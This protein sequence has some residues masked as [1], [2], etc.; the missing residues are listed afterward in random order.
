MAKYK[1]FEEVPVWQQA[2]AL[3]NA[4]LDLL[5]AHHTLLT[6]GYRNQL[7]RCAL[8]ISNNIAEGF[9][10]LTTGELISFLGIARGSA[11]ETRS[12]VSAVIDRPGLKSV[13][14]ELQ[15]IRVLAQSCSKQLTAWVT[16]IEASPIE[17]KRHQTAE[18]KSQRKSD[19]AAR[20]MRALFLSRIGP[21]HPL[22][23]TEDAKKARANPPRPIWLQILEEE[24][25]ERGEDSR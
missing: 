16:S 17:G 9:E 1:T 25:R 4:V 19:Q 11:G 15:H 12:M 5:Q 2:V 8:S 7:D 21:D 3:Y 20:D 23:S 14:K 18:V 13:R 6:P 24:L 22:Y 10:R